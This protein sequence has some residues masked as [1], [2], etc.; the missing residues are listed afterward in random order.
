MKTLKIT[1]LL[2]LLAFTNYSCKKDMDYEYTGYV[3]IHLGYSRYIGIF[4]LDYDL[5]NFYP[6][7]AIVARENANGVVKIELN[8]GNYVCANIFRTEH[9]AFQVRAG[10]TT[11]ITF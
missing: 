3:E 4:C 7:D 2:F 10:E 9:I 11:K 5:N 1:I 6:S 8:P